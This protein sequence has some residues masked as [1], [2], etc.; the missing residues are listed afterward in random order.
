MNEEIANIKELVQGVIAEFGMLPPGGRVVVGLSGGAD[1]MALT[2]FLVYQEKAEVLAA[3]VNHGLRGAE[4]DAD[5]AFVRKWCAE[6]HI[7]LRV[8]HADVKRLAEERK[9]GLEECG[10]EVRYAF[11]QELAQDA[12]IATAHTLSDNAETVLLNLTKGTGARGL[13][14]I[15]PVRGNII[16]PLIRATREQVEAYCRFY[17]LAYVTDSSNLE[18]NFARN[19]VRLDVVPVLKRINPAFEKEI[20]GMTMRL[21]RDELFLQGQ[22]EQAVRRAETP[23]GYDLAVLKTLARPVLVRAAAVILRRAGEVRL[24][25]KHLEAAA[26]VIAAGKGSVSVAGG[27]QIAAQGNTLFVAPERMEPWSVPVS[28]PVTRTPDGRSICLKKINKNAVQTENKF[29]NLLFH[30][31]INCDTIWT[32]PVFRTRRAGDVFR[33]AGRGV[34]KSLKKL[35][36]EAKLEPLLRDKV[37]LL[38]SGGEILWIEG[39]GPAESA[40]VLPGTQQAVT[41]R[42]EPAGSSAQVCGSQDEWE[43]DG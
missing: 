14:G 11:F 38:E 27:I 39:F 40:R 1:S 19:R 20:A 5:E 8:L 13:C 2:H 15:P 42:V 26:D 24:E 21:A 41:I 17:G 33:P 37:I 43:R 28:F 18:R 25:S 12:R 35:F 4:S 32:N 36:N 23:H 34:S 3:H 31:C 29:H 10:R 30:N 22:A 6:N 7:P 9:Q 16:R